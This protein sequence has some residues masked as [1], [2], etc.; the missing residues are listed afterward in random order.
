MIVSVKPASLPE[1]VFGIVG[2]IGIDID[3]IVETITNSLDGV[4]YSAELIKLTQEMMS[5]PV[6]VP[7][8]DSKCFADEITYKMDYA[9]ALCRKFQD[10]A[11]LARIGVRAIMRRRAT[12][13]SNTSAAS[14]TAY[15]IRQLKRPDEVDLLR[16]LY[17]KQFV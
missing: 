3:Q 5:E 12:L 14:A 17:G 9:S 7:A 4:G 8:P 16:Q 1:L 10:P 15:I 6:D 13:T 2:A 11:T